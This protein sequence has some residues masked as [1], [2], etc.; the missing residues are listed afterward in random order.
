[1]E[2][3]SLEKKIVRMR[4]N[5][6]TYI[7]LPLLSIC[8]GVVFCIKILYDRNKQQVS[9][10]PQCAH[11]SIYRTAQLLGI[12][13]KKGEIQRL[14]PNNRQGHSLVQIVETLGK[15][16][17]IAEGFNDNWETLAKVSFPCIVHLTAPE[18]FIVVSGIELSQGFVHVFDSDGNRT[19]QRRETFEKRWTGYA[20]HVKKDDAFFATSDKSKPRAVY[21]H[22]IIDKGDIPAVGEPTEF[23]FPIHNRGTADLVVDDVKVGCACLKS[24]KPNLPI[25]PG[26]SGVI[27]L[28]YTVESKHGVFTQTA[29]V[30]TNDPDYP[31]IVLSACGFTGVDIRIEPLAIRLNN[32]FVGRECIYRCFVHY[33]G[34]WNDFQIEFES[35]RVE[36]ITLLRHHFATIDK[37]DF[38]YLAY[39]NQTNFNISEKV[40]RN[41]RI[42]ELVFKPIGEIDENINGTISFKTNVP[43][44]E[45]F[46]LNISGKIVSPVQA[47]PFVVDLSNVPEKTVTLV[48]VMDKP[49]QVIEV[50]GEYVTC[51]FDSERFLD[52][53]KLSLKKSSNNPVLV[54][55]KYKLQND[56]VT[57]DLPITIFTDEM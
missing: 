56:P 16:G 34:E 50:R 39:K 40:A 51:Q 30:H 33:N 36:G 1:M 20:L 45:K 17:I 7:I 47:F 13:T 35:N 21:D 8:I 54:N 48:S 44:Y 10:T 37:T 43:G 32:L 2:K 23:I 15:I 18:H 3:I 28:F 14:L 24:E 41:S 42:L 49:F 4:N 46:T 12:P 9:D 57:Y 11:W 25:P 38:S 55:V 53:H 6:F 52:E 19:R 29:A 5:S 27:K 31:V 26:G 22:L